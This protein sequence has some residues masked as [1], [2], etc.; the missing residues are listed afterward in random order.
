[1]PLLREIAKHH[2]ITNVYFAAVSRLQL[3]Q[4]L[5]ESGFPRTILAYN[6]YAFPF[7]EGV[8]K[9]FQYHLIAKAFIYFFQLCYFT[10]Q[11]AHFHLQRY[12]VIGYFLFGHTLYIIK[13][14]LPA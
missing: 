10:T 8:I 4:H 7:F 1:E 5:Q 14:I 3:L 13:I 6:A 9:A 11:S 12:L 2:S